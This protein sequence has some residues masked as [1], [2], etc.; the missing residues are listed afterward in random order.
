VPAVRVVAARASSPPTGDA[1]RW[2]DLDLDPVEVRPVIES[3][4]ALRESLLARSIL[5]RVERRLIEG[6]AV[7]EL[8]Q[9][10]RLSADEV[11]EL[12]RQER[13]L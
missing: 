4:L 5:H 13:D 3:S 1:A 12:L 11:D 10:H 9:F 8:D 6:G 2:L 7:L